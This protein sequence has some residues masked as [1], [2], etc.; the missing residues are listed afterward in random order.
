M[1]DD[2]AIVK[3]MLARFTANAAAMAWPDQPLLPGEETTVSIMGEFGDKDFVFQVVVH[4]GDEIIRH[5]A[6]T[7]WDAA[8]FLLRWSDTPIE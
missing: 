1:T 6:Y 3:A 8:A 5:I 4:R 7:G 2:V